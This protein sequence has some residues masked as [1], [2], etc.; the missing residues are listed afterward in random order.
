M[1]RSTGILKLEMPRDSAIRSVRF[2][3]DDHGHKTAVVIDLKK[4]A[5]LWEDF[6]DVALAAARAR[7]PRESLASVRR[8]LA[9]RA[10]R[11]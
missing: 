2:L 11:R 10:K 3:V 5:R 7:E 9:V 1:T 4:N 6:Y 8:R